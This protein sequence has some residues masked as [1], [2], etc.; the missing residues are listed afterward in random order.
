MR[1]PQ[2]LAYGLAPAVLVLGVAL[3]R[4]NVAVHD[5]TKWTGGGFAMFSTVD[6]PGARALRAYVVTDQGEALAVEPDYGIER[7]LVYT[8]PKQERLH[9][10]AQ[11]LAAQTWRVYDASTYLEVWPSLPDFLQRYFQRSDAWQAAWT[12]SASTEGLYPGHLAFAARRAPYNGRPAEVAITGARVEV[13]KPV[14]DPDAEELSWQRIAEATAQT[15]SA[16]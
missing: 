3:Q 7:R 12:D 1:L 9:A 6:V 5:Q 11:H 4:Y 15:A 10:V 13:W 16:E 8:Q 14:F 2:W